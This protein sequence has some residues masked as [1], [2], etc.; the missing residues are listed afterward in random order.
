MGPA[1]EG[2]MS[3][4]E[5]GAMLRATTVSSGS[6]ATAMKALATAALNGPGWTTRGQDFDL[7][8]ILSGD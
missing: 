6:F 4:S 8:V 1:T 2:R 7:V 5:T 3:A